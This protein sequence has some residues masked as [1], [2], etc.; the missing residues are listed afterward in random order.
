MLYPFFSCTFWLILAIKRSFVVKT[1]LVMVMIFPID[2]ALDLNRDKVHTLIQN[3][4]KGREAFERLYEYMKLPLAVN[5]P[6]YAAI[7]LWLLTCPCSWRELAWTFYRCQLL[8]AV[9]KVK[10][11]IIEGEN[12]Y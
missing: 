9:I 2:V 6:H 3:H 7:D 11:F 4:V 10:T 5:M 12:Q 8:A 1:V